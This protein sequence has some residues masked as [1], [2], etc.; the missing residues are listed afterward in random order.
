MVDALSAPLVLIL[1][2]NSSKVPRKKIFSVPTQPATFY[3]PA[4]PVKNRSILA[5]FTV[6]KNS[7]FPVKNRCILPNFT[8]AEKQQ[9]SGKFLWKFR[10][11][12]QPCFV[13]VTKN[14][15]NSGRALWAQKV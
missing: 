3:T 7:K 9:V 2:R 14:L 12:W 4:D 1:Q 15:T 8:V 6:A 13:D 5:N 10:G 11:I